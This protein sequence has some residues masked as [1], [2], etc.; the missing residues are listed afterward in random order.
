M[1]VFYLLLYFT[2]VLIHFL[3]ILCFLDKISFS[4]RKVLTH[5]ITVKN[6]VF[7]ICFSEKIQSYVHKNIFETHM[8]SN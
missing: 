3:R 2:K 5:S 8:S 6:H 7:G 1:F 4:V